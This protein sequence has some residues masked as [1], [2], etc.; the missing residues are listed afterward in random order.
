MSLSDGL[1]GIANRRA[2]DKRIDHD[3][4]LAVR[5]KWPLSVILFDVDY[6]KLYNDS[7]GHAVGDEC[8]RKLASAVKNVMRRDQDFI[9]RYGGEEFVCILSDTDY[10]GAAV[11]STTLLE[12]V[13]QL[14]IPHSKSP[15]SQYV[16]VS[17]GSITAWPSHTNEISAIKLL[18]RADEALYE[19]KGGGRNKKVNFQLA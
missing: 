4:Q 15:I 2:F 3:I 17:L 8:L 5:H 6:F 16:T 13:R 10:E 7:Y 12:T 9:A 19:A 18:Q 1:T 11:V 14:A